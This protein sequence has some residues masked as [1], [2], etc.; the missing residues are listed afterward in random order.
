[1]TEDRPY[2]KALTTAEACTEILRGKSTQFDPEL[3]DRFA[4]ML[5]PA[6]ATPDANI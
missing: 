3:A 6:G 1:M 5:V 4:V 2:R